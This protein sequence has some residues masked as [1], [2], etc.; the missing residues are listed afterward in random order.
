[1]KARWDRMRLNISWI[2]IMLIGLDK[3]HG[4][5]DRKRFSQIRI[6]HILCLEQSRTKSL[7]MKNKFCSMVLHEDIG[8]IY[9]ELNYNYG[10]RT[11]SLRY[12]NKLLHGWP[13]QQKR[14]IN[15]LKIMSLTMMVL[16]RL[17]FLLCRYCKQ[18]S[19]YINSY[20]SLILFSY[21]LFP[22]KSWTNKKLLMLLFLFL[23][24][25]EISFPLILYKLYVWQAWR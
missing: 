19:K 23:F 1:M 16:L 6:T 2:R 18:Y 4:G 12:R 17:L 3:D 11:S 10:L 8:F 25:L 24:L 22:W 9:L 21:S 15:M 5:Y 14:A 20:L 7:D 13:K